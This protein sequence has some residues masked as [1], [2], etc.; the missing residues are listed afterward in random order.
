MTWNDM[1]YPT[2]PK[3]NITVNG[4]A[5]YYSYHCYWPGCLC[6]K[7]YRTPGYGVRYVLTVLVERRYTGCKNKWSSLLGKQHTLTKT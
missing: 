3:G 5:R 1:W 6:S 7:Y 2:L 4:Y